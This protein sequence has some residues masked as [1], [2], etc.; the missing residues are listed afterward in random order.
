MADQEKQQM[1]FAFLRERAGSGVAFT[2]DELSEA[3]G[4]R[5]QT[6]KT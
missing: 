6:A 5:G 3:V 4:W 2:V 1:A